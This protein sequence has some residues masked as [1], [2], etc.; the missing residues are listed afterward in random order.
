VVKRNRITNA[1]GWLAN[2][3]A[4]VRLPDGRL[5]RLQYVT[6]RSRI[7]TVNV[8]GR[9]VRL[10]FKD[11]ERVERGDYETFGTVTAHDTASENV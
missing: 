5:G 11:C 3:A 8:A 2:D 6:P 7:A 10:P 4:L 9:R 1:A